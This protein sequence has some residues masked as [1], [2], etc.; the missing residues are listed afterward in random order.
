MQESVSMTDFGKPG[1]PV[2][3]ADAELL[4]EWL[5]LA[6]GNLPGEFLRLQGQDPAVFS[7]LGL[8]CLAPSRWSDS[9]VAGPLLSL[10]TLNN[11]GRIPAHGIMD[12]RL[13]TP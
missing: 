10:H 11:A 1:A 9:Y 8:L 12:R 13:G 6:G 3:V 2:E 7:S 5:R 4:R